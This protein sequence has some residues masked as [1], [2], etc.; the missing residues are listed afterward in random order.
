[1]RRTSAPWARLVRA[2]GNLLDDLPAATWTAPDR[3]RVQTLAC[4]EPEEAASWVTRTLAME[5]LHERAGRLPVR[6]IAGQDDRG[7][8]VRALRRLLTDLDDE[9]LSPEAST[10]DLARTLGIAG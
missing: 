8:A 7:G 9:R 4:G 1:M 6:A 10:L 2:Q 5:P 3:A